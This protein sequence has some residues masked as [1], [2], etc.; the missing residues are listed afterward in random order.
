MDCAGLSQLYTL[1]KIMKPNE[2]D[3]ED[4]SSRI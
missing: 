4:G 1:V 2:P 3:S